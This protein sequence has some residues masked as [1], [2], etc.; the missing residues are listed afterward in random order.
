[1]S[2]VV[3]AGFL[4]TPS[5]LKTQGWLRSRDG[6]IVETG[7]GELPEAGE[8]LAVQ[9]FT[10]AG[11]SGLGAGPPCGG[12]EPIGHAARQ[13]GLGRIEARVIRIEVS[14]I[15]GPALATVHPGRRRGPASAWISPRLRVLVDRLFVG[16]GI[17][18]AGHA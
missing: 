18:V 10:P 17:V 15:A 6:V 7:A 16:E 9:Y 12:C 14:G 1:V 11:G 2:L 13:S 8:S 5:G 3:R 4:L